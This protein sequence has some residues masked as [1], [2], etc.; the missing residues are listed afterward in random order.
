MDLQSQVSR[1]GGWPSWPIRGLRQWPVGWQLA[2]T[3]PSPTCHLVKNMVKTH[4][5][6]F[7]F[8]PGSGA[9]LSGLAR[10]VRSS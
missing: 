5:H 3:F 4:T 7:A 2:A 6:E 1:A 10:I 9:I 8:R